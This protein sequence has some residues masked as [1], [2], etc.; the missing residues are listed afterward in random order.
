V[1]EC[2]PAGRAKIG[3]FDFVGAASSEWV[4]VADIKKLNVEEEEIEGELVS[5]DLKADAW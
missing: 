4:R 1:G 3:Q 5:R 2:V